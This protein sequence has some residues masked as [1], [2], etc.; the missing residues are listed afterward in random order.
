MT[1]KDVHTVDSEVEVPADV[2]LVSTT[3]L[4]GVIT[5]A[6]PVFCRIA[7]YTV[8]ELVGQHHNMVRHP[9]MPKVA[10]ADLWSHLKEGNAWRGLVKNRCKDGRYYWVDAYV[11]PI[12]TDGKVTGY[13]SVRCR[14]NAEHKALANKIYPELRA[15]EGSTK[16]MLHN[17][18]IPPLFSV[19][20]M[21]ATIAGI[22]W[23]LPPLQA[24]SV[25]LPLLIAI[26]F[27]RNQL[28]FTPRFFQQLGQDY[29]S[30]SRLIFSGDAPHSIADFHIKLWQARIRTVLGR[31]EDAT[32]SLQQLADNLSSS[33]THASKDISSQDLQIQQVATAVTE[34]ATAAHEINRSI[35]DSNQQIEEA[36]G[37]CLNTDTQ[38]VKASSEI[39]SLANQAEQAFQSATE[40]A[41]E[42]ERIGSIMSEIQG[43]ADQ[44]NL[45]ALNAA[46][47]AARAG[48][49]GR[50]FAVV[51]DEVRHLS[52][53]THRATEQ[54]Q[55]SIGHI[56]HTLGG[57]KEMMHENL[58][59]THS[60]LGTTRACSDNLHQILS[61]IDNVSNFSGQ[62]SS[63]ALQ[64]QAV[65]E[66]ISRN[67]N[68]LSSLSHDNSQKI[69][70]VSATSE[71]LLNKA[72]QLKGLSQ[73]FG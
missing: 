52:T 46:I 31:V 16:F 33:A 44:T 43:I 18:Q 29:D 54:I 45:L 70:E 42:S 35:Q 14:A 65:V 32:H 38:L 19:F 41:S 28:F 13:Q 62:I 49:Q 6:N 37:H 20:L 27:N 10:F 71:T 8:E 47:E 9:D 3:D 39:E 40:L 68:L 58:T 30:I 24:T 60:C 63:A 64:Q 55:G 1:R 15:R 5:Y 26:W 73:T 57:W 36:R 21:L 34:M 56:Q 50:G 48:E 69:D 7:G 72:S 4:K 25:A 12:Y 23:L 61:E 67:I 2:Q 51:A 59:M 17:V 53:R 22:A 11:T 66:E